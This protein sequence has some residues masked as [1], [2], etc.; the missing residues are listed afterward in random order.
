MAMKRFYKFIRNNKAVTAIEFAILAPVFFLIF[1]GIIEVGLTMFVDSTMNTALRSAARKGIPDGYANVQ[2]FRNVMDNYMGGIYRDGPKMIIAVESIAPPSKD[3]AGNINLA[4][5]EREIQELENFSAQFTNDP[6]SFFIGDK[7]RFAPSLAQQSG[8]I[9][10]YTARYEWGGFTE[11]V[12]VFLPDHLY[13]VSIV[14]NE[15]FD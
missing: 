2:D 9:T 11:L 6:N 14:R 12:G 4:D 10:I 15:V 8:A 13:A 1:M 5:S 3:A 7:D